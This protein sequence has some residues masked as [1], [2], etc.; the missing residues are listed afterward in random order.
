MQLVEPPPPTELTQA[1]IHS[2]DETE[3][4]DDDDEDDDDEEDEEDFKGVFSFE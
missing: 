2:N 3:N 1:P 4:D